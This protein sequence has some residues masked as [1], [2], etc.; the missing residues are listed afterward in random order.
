MPTTKIRLNLRFYL[1]PLV[2]TPYPVDQKTGKP[3]SNVCELTVRARSP[4]PANGCVIRVAG[5][6]SEIKINKV[7]LFL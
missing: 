4:L 1:L 2:Y 5:N 7:A 6:Y 3:R